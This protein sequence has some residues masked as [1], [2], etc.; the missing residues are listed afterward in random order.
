MDKKHRIQS[1]RPIEQPMPKPPVIAKHMRPSFSPSVLSG[2][3]EAMAVFSELNPNANASSECFNRAHVWAYEEYTKRGLN[4]MKVFM[5]F[6][7][8]FIRDWGYD[9]WFHVSPFVYTGDGELVVDAYFTGQPLSMKDWTD[10]FIYS[11][12]ECPEISSYSQ[13]SQHQQE[14]DCYLY[15]GSMFFWQ[16]MDVEQLEIDGSEK[17]EFIQSEVDAAYSQGF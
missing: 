7:D 4:S 1:V 14:N 13:Y 2:Y 15:K 3:G 17:T 12:A 10:S 9:W 8:K 6:T 11:Q 16:P 5:F